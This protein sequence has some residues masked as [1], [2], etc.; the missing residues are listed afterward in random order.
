MPKGHYRVTYRS[1]P[2]TNRFGLISQL[3]FDESCYTDAELQFRTRALSYRQNSGLAPELLETDNKWFDEDEDAALLDV[4]EQSWI[5]NSAWRPK[6]SIARD[7]FHMPLSHNQA[8]IWGELGT[9]IRFIG[10][11]LLLRNRDLPDAHLNQ[12]MNFILLD[13]AKI[14]KRLA[15]HPDGQHVIGQ[16]SLLRKYLRKIETHVSPTEGRDRLFV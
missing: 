10:D 9:L 4:N 3:W 15:V 7:H 11:Y 8:Y 1:M 13:V 5:L 6:T 16:I 2:H 14:L 12:P